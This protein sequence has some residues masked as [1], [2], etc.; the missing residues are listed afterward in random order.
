MNYPF[1]GKYFTLIEV[2]MPAN[3]AA[4]KSYTFEWQSQVQTILGDQR[5]AVEA[6][7]VYTNLAITHSPLTTTFPVAAPADIRNTSLTLLFGTFEGISTIPLASLCRTL[8]DQANYSPAVEDLTLFREMQKVDW[9]RSKVT[10]VNTA[11]TVTEFSY[12]FGVWYDYL[13]TI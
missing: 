3:S 6:I 7:E 1:R 10:L 13:P 4:N 11:P 2:K 12:L 8:P 9:V 5:V